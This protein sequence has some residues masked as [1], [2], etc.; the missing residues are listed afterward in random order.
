MRIIFDYVVSYSSI[1]NPWFKESAK[2]EKNKEFNLLVG[3]DSKMESTG[4][5][6]KLTIGGQSYSLH[7]LNMTNGNLNPIPPLN[8][9]SNQT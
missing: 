4:N 1:D 2:Q 6:Y 8:M 3:T 9:V 7:K 5:K